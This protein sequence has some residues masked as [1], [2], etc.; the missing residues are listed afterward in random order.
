MIVYRK[1]LELARY[2]KT[3]SLKNRTIIVFFANEE[4]PHFRTTR[5]G[6]YQFAQRFVSGSPSLCAMFSLEMLGYYDA[7][8]GSQKYPPV[9]NWFYPDTG[10]FVGIV[11][12]TAGRELIGRTTASFHKSSSVRAFGF[13][14][15]S[16]IK[17]LDFSDHLPFWE[18]GLPALMITDTSFFRNPNYHKESDLP[19]T[20]DFEMMSK[21]VGGLESV[22]Q[23]FGDG[24][25][26]R[27]ND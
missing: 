18:E 19:E 24:S 26:S 27:L 23:E 2:L 9:L 17:G 5:M 12:N 21:V 25:C 3:V 15:P 6:S 1:S 10:D 8:P 4:P 11:G 14:G 16:W 13:A 7:T 20:L 22:V